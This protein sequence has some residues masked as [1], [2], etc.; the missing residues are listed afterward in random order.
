LKSAE[1]SIANVKEIITDVGQVSPN[2]T[3]VVKDSIDTVR[4][5]AGHVTGKVMKD[6]KNKVST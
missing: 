6:I 2:T 4:N 3:K 1:E 5:E